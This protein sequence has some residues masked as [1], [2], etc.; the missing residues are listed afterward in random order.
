MRLHAMAAAQGLVLRLIGSV[1]VRLRCP[2]SAYLFEALGRR[3]YR[4]I[5]F[6][7]YGKQKRELERLFEADGWVPDPA[8]KYSQEYEIKRLIY[9]RPSGD[10]KVDVFLDEL[11]MAHTIDLRGRLELDSPTVALADL[12]LSKLQIHDVTDDDLIDV[13]VLLAEHEVDAP[14][15]ES[16]DLGRVLKLMRSDWGFYHTTMLNLEKARAVLTA[17]DLGD[18]VATAI[19]ARL[20]GLRNKIEG[21][22]KMLRWK[23]RAQVGTSVRWY[24]DV[25][26][27]ERD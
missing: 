11:E 25:P 2:R 27:V 4:D 8:L 26:E 14:G 20:T 22:P 9:S 23:L 6:M 12:L 24:Q 10:P 19:E 21:E 1:A 3:P 7:G 5:D 15:N 18:A 13:L 16:L 17:A